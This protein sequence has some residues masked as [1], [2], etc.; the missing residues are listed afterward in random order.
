MSELSQGQRTILTYL[1]DNADDELPLGCRITQ[2]ALATALGI[3]QGLARAYLLTLEAEGWLLIDRTGSG[4]H[5]AAPN[6]YV[7]VSL[8]TPPTPALVLLDGQA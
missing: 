3:S 2:E 1:L 4:P 8:G 6:R 7:L 5:R